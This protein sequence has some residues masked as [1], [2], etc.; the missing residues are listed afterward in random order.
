MDKAKKDFRSFDTS[1]KSYH[2]AQP[3]ISYIGLRHMFTQD[4]FP[5]PYEK[6]V[7]I[8]PIEKLKKMNGGAAP[9]KKEIKKG[10]TKFNSNGNNIVKSNSDNNFWLSNINSG[11][12]I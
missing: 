1:T 9:E 10:I 3:Q 6:A 8:I 7:S 4:Y 11:N 2:V 12:V 5:V